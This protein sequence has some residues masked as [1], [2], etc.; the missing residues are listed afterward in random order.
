MSITLPTPV[1]PERPMLNPRVAAAEYASQVLSGINAGT[2]T[3]PAPTSR[4]MGT[5]PVRTAAP[6]ITDRVSMV[7]QSASRQHQDRLRAL[8]G[9]R[10]AARAAAYGSGG[11]QSLQAPRGGFT[12]AFTGG[13]HGL[14]PGAGAAFQRLNTA[15]RKRFKQDLVVNSGGRSREDQA[16]AY[17][18]YGPSQAAAPGHSVHESG[19]A[20][21]LGGPVLNAQSIQHRWLQQNAGNFGWNW[22]GKNFS[23]FEPWHWEYFG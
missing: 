15:Y 5:T 11:A 10:D 4:N 19:R 17:R 12:G 2:D 23:T 6:K 14:T 16:E 20:L 21:D 18:K 8:N 22:T 7:S 1:R 3:R 13:V 9:G